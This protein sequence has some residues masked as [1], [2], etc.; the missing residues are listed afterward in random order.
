MAHHAA[1]I[2]IRQEPHSL[3]A[4]APRIARLSA[5]IG[6][7]FLAASLLLGWLAH[8]HL[9]HFWHAYLVNFCYFLSIS[10]GALFFLGITNLCSGRWSI[11]YRRVVELIAC[12]VPLMALLLVPILVSLIMGSHSLYEWN[13]PANHEVNGKRPYLNVPFLLIRCLIY[14]GF[15]TILARWY[16]SESLRQDRT[17]DVAINDRMKRVSAPALILGGLTLTFFAFDFLMAL[18]PMWVSTIFGVYYF[19]G[20]GVAIFATLI[21]VTYLLQRN[22]ILAHAITKEH[23]HDLGKFLFGFVFFW[24][25]IGFSQFMLIWY[26]NMP[27]ETFWYVPRYHGQ[28]AVVSY[29][30]IYG[31]FVI[32]FIGLMGRHV[33]R[34]PL[35]LVFWAVWMLIMHWVDL[36]WV[37]MPHLNMVEAAKELAADPHMSREKYNL[38]LG[39]V[40][41]GLM[42][43]TLLVG[44]GGVYIAYF[45]YLAGSV[46]LIAERD[47]YL[48]QSLAFKNI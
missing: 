7:I 45:F 10:L 13:N 28:W 39:A 34:T 20:C 6:V 33:K 11:V 38:I 8:D 48:P 46:P 25:Y 29:I 24:G 41:F 2:D 5:I 14:F 17:G 36:Y 31:H 32:P 4:V 37:V 27:E 3:S 47:P 1:V 15:W 16:M 30:L 18:T 35:A 40:Q 43:L 22:G 21:L 12:T 9:A 42:D 23:Y 26:G 44:M 19:G